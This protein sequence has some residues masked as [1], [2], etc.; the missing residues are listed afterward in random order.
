M[1]SDR[2]KRLLDI[3]G[4]GTGLIVL[5]PLFAVIA[6]AVYVDDRGPIIF[7][8][9]RVGQNGREFRMLKFRSMLPH[10]E[11]HGGLLTVGKDQRI[12]RIGTCLLR[13]KLDTWPHPVDVSVEE[14]A[15][16]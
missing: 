3:I 16:A 11:Q 2:S 6:L 5:A 12:T 14:G 1:R 8:Q 13:S 15:M 7:R 4:A 9:T 10:A